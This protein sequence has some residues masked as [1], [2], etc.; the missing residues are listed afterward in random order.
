MNPTLTLKEENLL[1]IAG[2]VYFTDKRI[3]KKGRENSSISLGELRFANV[4]RQR[5]SWILYVAIGLV[6]F[7]A[8]SGFWAFNAFLISGILLTF[9]T[10]GCYCMMKDE[11]L[12]VNFGSRS[13]C[14]NTK[15]LTSNAHRLANELEAARFKVQ[16]KTG[17]S[18]KQTR[19]IKISA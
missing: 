10:F 15:T 8:I 1:G 18:K 12:N 14:V 17:P 5:K 13:I 7:S 2:N 11:V 16:M 9:T 4:Q 19:T 6:A 3:F